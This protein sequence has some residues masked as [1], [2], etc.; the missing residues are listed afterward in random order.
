MTKPKLHNKEICFSCVFTC[1]KNS[2]C[3]PF[4]S[5]SNICILDF[6]GICPVKYLLLSCSKPLFFYFCFFNLMASSKRLNLAK[7]CCAPN[8]RLIKLAVIP[9]SYGRENIGKENKRKTTD[10]R[11]YDITKPRLYKLN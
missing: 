2:N 7:L 6:F 4:P 11:S 5:S 3:N 1:F 10:K 9:T 8:M